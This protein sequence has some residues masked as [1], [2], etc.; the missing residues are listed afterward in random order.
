M[1]DLLILFMVIGSIPL[2]FMRPWIG[3]IMWCWLGFMNPHRLT[4]GFA[5]DFAFAQLIALATLAAIVISKEKKRFD[6]TPLVIVW[7][8]W[9]LWMNVTTYFALEPAGTVKDYDR[10]M[11]TMLF[12]FLTILLINNEIKVRALVWI[13]VLS[14]GF[15]GVKGGIFSATTGGN[16]LVWGPPGSFI[17]GNNE[18]GLALVMT[19]PLMFYLVFTEENKW[20]KR[21]M[22]GA[23]GL[24]ALAV[25]TTFSRGA[26]LALGG[27]GV[28]LWLKSKRKIVVGLAFVIAIPLL[29]GFMPD[30]WVERMWSIRSYDDDGSAQGRFNAW[31]FRLLSGAGSPAT[32]RWI[33]GLFTT[34]IS[35]LRP[36][37]R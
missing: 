14:L 22:M 12:A 19:I 25:L 18:L 32:R 31:W 13:T 10:A 17:E 23:I 7:L 9:I 26:F 11:K 27:M 16:Y 6:L 2:I 29:L 8:A 15:F 1:R 37:R 3:I 4:W 30:T 5:Y 36:S 35:N 24:T 21:G 33:W 28:F 20:I 34:S